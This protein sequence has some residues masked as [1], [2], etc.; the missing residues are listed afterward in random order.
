MTHATATPEDAAALVIDEAPRFA[1]PYRIDLPGGGQ[2]VLH[3]WCR[4]LGRRAVA[5]W[6]QGAAGKTEGQW[7]AEVVTG[8]ATA[9]DVLDPANPSPAPAVLR[10]VTKA[11]EPV[12]FSTE[13]LD[14]LCD[15][16][17]TAGRCISLQYLRHLAG[18]REGN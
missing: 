1:A 8:W 17:Q 10:L 15:A 11:G 2:A 18:A 16:Y 6:L 3:L 13:A 7:L 4:A 5:Q 9:E 12:G 14:T